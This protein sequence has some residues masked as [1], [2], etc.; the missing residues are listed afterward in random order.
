MT[1]YGHERFRMPLDLD[2]L[3]PDVVMSPHPAFARLR[4]QDPVHWSERHRAWVL[5]RYDDQRGLP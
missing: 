1:G 2:L 4:E 3:A 5:T